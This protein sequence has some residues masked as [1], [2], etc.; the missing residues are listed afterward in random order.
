M[1]NLFQYHD[2]TLTLTQCYS[3]QYVE[4]LRKKNAIV[5]DIH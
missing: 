4:L 1:L 3:I 5:F 2:V